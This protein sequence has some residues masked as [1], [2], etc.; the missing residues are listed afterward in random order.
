MML[1]RLLLGANAAM[2]LALGAWVLVA[3]ATVAGFVAF[4][5]SSPT[6]R[7]EFLAFYGGFEL[8]FGAFLAA[9][10][11]RPA[12]LK[13]GL[14]ALGLALSCTGGARAFGIVTGG[15]VQANLVQFMVF[16]LA[17]APLC[18]IAFRRLGPTRRRG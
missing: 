9:C 14:V 17:C 12:W 3:P 6:A 16:E 1:A 13:P 15:P 4:D 8:G 2:F 18:L 11:T 5:L 10:A 7:A